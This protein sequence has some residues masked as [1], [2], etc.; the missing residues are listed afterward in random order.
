MVINL[1]DLT[2]LEMDT[3]TRTR[4]PEAG[5]CPP[6]RVPAGGYWVPTNRYLFAISSLVGNLFAGG[7]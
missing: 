6:S 5:T 1:G 3:R 2:K 7:D 4:H